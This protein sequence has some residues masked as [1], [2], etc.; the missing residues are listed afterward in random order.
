VSEY[1]PGPHDGSVSRTWKDTASHVSE[2]RTVASLA[3]DKTEFD[4]P[5]VPSNMLGPIGDADCDAVCVTLGVSVWE[6][7]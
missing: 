7:L 4:K 5:A 3:L 1:S 6:A 2:P